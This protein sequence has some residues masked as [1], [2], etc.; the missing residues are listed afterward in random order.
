[1]ALASLLLLD[2]LITA[3]TACSWLSVDSTVRPIIDFVP[4]FIARTK[5]VVPGSYIL[6]RKI[7]VTVAVV[8]FI[9]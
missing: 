8:S 6:P 3:S 1:M 9:F 2:D 7:L 5:R 4:V